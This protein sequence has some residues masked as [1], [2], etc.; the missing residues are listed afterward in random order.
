MG[1]RLVEQ[2]DSTYRAEGYDHPVRALVPIVPLDAFSTAL[3]D[4]QLGIAAK[5]DGLINY[6]YIPAYQP[7]GM[8]A[9][10]ALLYM[11]I[12]IDHELLAT[13]AKRIAQL[14]LEAAKQLKRK[15]VWLAGGIQVDRQ[16]F[17]PPRD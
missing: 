8:P 12:T 7:A 1:G 5:Y 3:T 6:M 16:D 10:L 14:S 13:A 17:R 11:P 2:P 15:T 9:G 4:A